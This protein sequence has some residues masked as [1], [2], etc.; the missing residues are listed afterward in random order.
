MKDRTIVQ[1]PNHIIEMV[2][3]DTVIMTSNLV[4]A[5]KLSTTLSDDFKIIFDSFDLND[6][7][8]FDWVMDA[9]GRSHIYIIDGDQSINPKHLLFSGMAFGA[10]SYQQPQTL[11]T[12]NLSNDMQ[13]LINIITKNQTTHFND[14]DALAFY[15]EN[16]E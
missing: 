7:D 2:G 8:H 6:I 13:N 11:L 10:I 16:E 15:I 14:I 4:L 1:Y 12:Y 3:V 5:N 9:M